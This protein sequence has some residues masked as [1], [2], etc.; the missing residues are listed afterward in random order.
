MRFEN[1]LEIDTE[2]VFR[3]L[4]LKKPYPDEQIRR[5]QMEVAMRRIKMAS[6]PRWTYRQFNIVV[7]ADHLTAKKLPDDGKLAQVGMDAGIQLAGTSVYFTGKD[8][9]KHLEN[10]SACL[11]LAVTL[12]SQVEQIIRAAESRD[13]SETVMLDTAASVLADQYADEAETILRRKNEKSGSFLT[14]RF[15]PG[16]G[17]F[18]LD[19]QPDFLQLVQAEKEIGLT[20]SQTYILLPRKSITAILGI[21]ENG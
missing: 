17:D 13:M 3:Y 14:G 10:C 1:S 2:M 11:L 8:I 5:Q 9:R 7:S 16:Y 4:G 19:I 21:R 20:V 6:M 12:G 18:S 15:S